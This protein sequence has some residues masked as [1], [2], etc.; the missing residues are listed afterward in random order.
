MNVLL[1][2]YHVW[3]V[4]AEARKGWQI[5]WNCRYSQLLLLWMCFELNSGSQQKQQVFVTAEVS[6]QTKDYPCACVC[7]AEL[8]PSPKD[9]LCVCVC[10]NLKQVYTS[11]KYMSREWEW[12]MDGREEKWSFAQ[13]HPNLS[14]FV[15]CVFAFI[16]RDLSS[17]YNIH[18]FKGDHMKI[19]IE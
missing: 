8:S 19:D 13:F 7:T 4:L 15:P 12:D 6:P 1:H 18:G 3:L 5:S 11:N 10:R 9:F 2:V 16:F 17:S 14:L